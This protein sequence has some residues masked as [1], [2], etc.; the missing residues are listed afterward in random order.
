VTD[1]VEILDAESGLRREVL[2]EHAR[3]ALRRADAT[4]HIAV[5]SGF[6]N[7]DDV[8]VTDLIVEPDDTVRAVPY[9]RIDVQRP[10][11]L[12]RRR[13]E[14]ARG[15]TWRVAP[16]DY[17]D[18]IATED[19]AGES[20]AGGIGPTMEARSRSD[21]ITVCREQGP[22]VRVWPFAFRVRARRPTGEAMWSS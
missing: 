7:A 9:D 1:T 2:D 16:L 18:F 11:E 10:T 5:V 19:S 6:V 4:G 20:T 3:I 21:S 15:A 8:N 14:A 22:D 17:H 12:A 13:L